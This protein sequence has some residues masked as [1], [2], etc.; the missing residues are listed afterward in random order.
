MMKI[1]KVMSFVAMLAPIGAA[2]NAATVDANY[3]GV[4][5]ETLTIY[6]GV[7][8]NPG[9]QRVIAGEFS[10]SST[11]LGNFAA[12]C[13]DLATSLIT[14]STTTVNYTVKENM[15]SANT[16]SNVQR[17]FDANYAEVDTKAERASFQLALWEM[18]YDM[19]FTDNNFAYV[20]GGSAGVWDRAD[21]YLAAAGDYTGRK[22]WNL[23]FLGDADPRSQGVVTMTEV[24]P[25]PL[26]AAG[27]LLLGGLGGLG[28]IARRRKSAA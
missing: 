8:S 3:Q 28:V 1:L 21:S 25:V 13:V 5:G 17:L 7:K 27:L 14:N 9:N 18:L 16:I 26:P 11:A 2:A 24:A 4:S 6:N 22:L 23:T 10:F 12:Y 19:D 15:F 20:S